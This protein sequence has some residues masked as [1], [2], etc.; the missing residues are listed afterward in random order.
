VSARRRGT[1]LKVIQPD[2]Q[3]TCPLLRAGTVTA[4]FCAERQHA[5][6][7]GS[8]RG[9]RYYP[10]S[11]LIHGERKREIVFRCEVGRARLYQM[12]KEWWPEHWVPLKS[13]PKLVALHNAAKRRWVT[14]HS[15]YDRIDGRSV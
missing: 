10:C 13:N 11:Y 7:T 2:D 1:K 15:P 8:P 4:H 9:A 5:R 3:V 12:A 6:A 14:T